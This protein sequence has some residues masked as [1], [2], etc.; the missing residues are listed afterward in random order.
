VSAAADTPVFNDWLRFQRFAQ[1]AGFD[2]LRFIAVVNGKVVTGRWLDAFLGLIHFDG[3]DG[4]VTVDQMDEI[5]P[6]ARCV[7]LPSSEPQP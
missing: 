2:S 7:V 1:D 3:M 4:F 5:A 6:S